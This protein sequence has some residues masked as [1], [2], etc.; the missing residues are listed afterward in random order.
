MPED[1]KQERLPAPTTGAQ[2]PR[3]SATTPQRD[4]SA[5]SHSNSNSNPSSS[6]KSALKTRLAP[7][8]NSA[9]ASPHT[10]RNTSPIRKESRPPLPGPFATQPSAAAIQR[11]LSAA[12]VPQLHATP[13]SSDNTS[14]LPRAHKSASASA[15]STPTWP[16]SPRLK[17]PPPSSTSTARSSSSMSSQNKAPTT[18][19]DPAASSKQG[20][21]EPARRPDQQLLTPSK[22]A[23][24]GPSGKSVLET[25]QENS[26]DAVT[27]SPAAVQA[28]Q[29]LKPLSRISD[30][31]AAKRDVS[32]A[33]KPAESGNESTGNKSDGQRGRRSSLGQSAASSQKPKAT[34]KNGYGTLASAKSRGEGKQG[35]T[36]ETETVSSIPQSAMNTGDRRND[37]SGSV[38]LK[39][40]SETIRPKKDRKKPAQKPRSITQGTGEYQSP[41]PE[42]RRFHPASFPHLPGRPLSREQAVLGAHQTVIVAIGSSY[43]FAPLC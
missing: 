36:V 29:D 18:P 12:N 4:A 24:R 5:Q 25:V 13:N 40:S 42:P 14:R 35:M 1:S 2:E 3:D 23:S 10:S 31:N 37:H 6:S 17:S 20:D 41:R 16:A 7:Q 38:R 32:D 43:R 22:T 34:T 19:S 11:A 30:N 28:S 33:D 15:E 27:P 26:T 39:P 21:E 8:N 9:E